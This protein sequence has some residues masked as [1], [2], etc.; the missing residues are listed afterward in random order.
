[1]D[2]VWI[3]HIDMDAF[4]ASVEQLDDPTL[5]G[6]PV[7]VGG[8]KRGVVSAA[9]YEARKFGVHSAMPIFQAKRLCPQGIFVPGRMSRYAEMSRQVMAILN[10]FSPLVEQASV[11]EAYLDATGLS[12]IFGPVEEMGY[13]IKQTVHDSTGLTCSVGIAP[14]KFLAKIASDLKKPDGLSILRPE[15]VD[16][17]LLT[18]PVEL[19]PGVGTRTL[20]TLRTMGVRLAGDMRRYPEEFWS[21]HLGK[22]GRSLYRRSLGQDSRVV[23]PYYE[24]KSESA[25]NTF[26]QDSGDREFLRTWLLRQSE[27]VGRSLRRQGI[28][29]RTVTLKVKYSDFTNVVR[30]RSLK[31]PTNLTKV[32]YETAVTL[33]DEL[34]PKKKLRLIGVGLSNFEDKPVRRIETT[35]PLPIFQTQSRHDQISEERLYGLDLE[36]EAAIDAALD[37]AQTKFGRDKLMRGKLFEHNPNRPKQT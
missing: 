30:S 31:N 28:K 35:L 5:R 15:E 16:E 27:R 26:E 2:N 29:G 19:I 12:R 32:I 23:E 37:A 1:M 20:E 22:A 18:M 9:S 6:K 17:F 7:I 13:R 11:D 24:A 21:K 10:N 34:D 14:V 25:E 4:F 33:L 3:M 36:K 8:G